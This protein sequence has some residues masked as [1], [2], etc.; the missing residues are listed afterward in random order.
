M[1]G[2]STGKRL[3]DFQLLDR[4]LLGFLDQRVEVEA[5]GLLEEL[6]EEAADPEGAAVGV[7]HAGENPFDLLERADADLVPVEEAVLEPGESLVGLVARRA[8]VADPINDR[9]EDRH[10]L[11]RRLA[12]VVLLER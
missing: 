4:F 12:L 11:G 8:F 10:L 1:I 2:S 7:G 9:L 6:A 5:V 3:V